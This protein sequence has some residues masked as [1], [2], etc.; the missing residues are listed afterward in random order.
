MS[1]FLNSYPHYYNPQITQNY[2]ITTFH[3]A[4][5]KIIRYNHTRQSM[6]KYSYAKKSL[7]A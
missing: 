2:Y 3:H 5:S 7:S 1:L 4:Y 6:I